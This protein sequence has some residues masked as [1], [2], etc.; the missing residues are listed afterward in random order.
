MTVLVQLVHRWGYL[1]IVVGTYLEGEGILL[2][3][4]ALCLAGVLSAPWVV[5]SATLGSLAWGQ[6]WFR[7]GAL[8]GRA[9]IGRHPV[10][11][12]RAQVVERWLARSGPA[13]LLCGR[14]VAGMGTLLPTVIGASGYAWPRFT[15]LDG[16]GALIWALVVTGA[17]WAL[18]AGALWVSPSLGWLGLLAVAVVVSLLGAL[19]YRHYARVVAR[20]PCEAGDGSGGSSNGRH[21]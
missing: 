11:Q 16:A 4:G 5:L 1:A 7:V 18:G 19:V 21:A 20:R 12:A 3:A 10:W 13:V 8:S 2:S 6:T 15:L 14:F 17:G 9:L